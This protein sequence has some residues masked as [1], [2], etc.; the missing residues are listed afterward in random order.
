MLQANVKRIT[1]SEDACAGQAIKEPTR[2]KQEINKEIY[3]HMKRS[4]KYWDALKEKIRKEQVA[5]ASCGSKALS[6]WL[7]Q[8]E[9]VL[10]N[11]RKCIA[12]Q[13]PC[14][15]GLLEAIERLLLC[16]QWLASPEELIEYRLY[17]GSAVQRANILCAL[18]T[19]N[20]DEL[21]LFYTE[22]TLKRLAA[23]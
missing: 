6:E 9:D 3:P 13:K 8:T 7:D 10:N 16:D 14:G 18:D 11:L 15:E 19:L 2:E 4:D 5:A 17:T 22:I 23:D 1:E 21:E 12:E 20:P